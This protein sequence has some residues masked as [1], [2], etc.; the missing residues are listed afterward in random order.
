MHGDISFKVK[1]KQKQTNTML[2]HACDG[3]RSLK[4]TKVFSKDLIRSIQAT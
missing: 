3:D 4:D 1:Q 2:F